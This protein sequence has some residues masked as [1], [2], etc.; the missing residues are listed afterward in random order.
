M[1][2]DIDWAVV[3]GDFIPLHSLQ[4]VFF[5][6]LGSFFPTIGV[7][8]K[9]GSEGRTLSFTTRSTLQFLEEVSMI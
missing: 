6:G 4:D 8:P 1:F 5:D 9:L 3:G 2:D 7:G